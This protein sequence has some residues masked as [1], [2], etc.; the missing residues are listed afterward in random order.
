[1]YSEKATS[2]KDVIIEKNCCRVLLQKLSQAENA[3][4]SLNNKKF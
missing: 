3:G 1:M 2:C 4:D